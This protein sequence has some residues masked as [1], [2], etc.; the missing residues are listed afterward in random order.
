MDCSVYSPFNQRFHLKRA[1][2]E[3]TEFFE[4]DC[5]YN[6]RVDWRSKDSIYT[7]YLQIQK[8]SSDST[9]ECSIVREK[10][11]TLP[12]SWSYIHNLKGCQTT[13]KNMDT[14]QNNICCTSSQAQKLTA[15]WILTTASLLSLTSA[16]NQPVSVDVYWN[17]SNEM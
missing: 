10:H 1:S 17:R 13:D 6:P 15:L 9:S 3:Y 16:N 14:S 2:C 12:W 4:A 5:S 7:R 11:F 8:T